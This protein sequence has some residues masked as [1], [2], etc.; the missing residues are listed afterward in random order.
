[1]GRDVL[2][3]SSL[4]DS[5]WLMG[6]TVTVHVVFLQL[7]L[8]DEKQNSSCR[9]REGRREVSFVSLLHIV[10]CLS[11]SAAGYYN[12]SF[13]LILWKGLKCEVFTRMK[14]SATQ[15]IQSSKERRSSANHCAPL[16]VRAIRLTE[17]FPNAVLVCDIVNES[18]HLHMQN[19]L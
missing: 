18:C 16:T 12:N 11:A 8:I 3:S 1:M 14:A 6:P 10:V 9:R 15:Y 19:V 2:S 13:T 5:G 4:L 7:S 17:I